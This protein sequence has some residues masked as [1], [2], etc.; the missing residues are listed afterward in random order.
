MK[1]ASKAILGALIGVLGLCSTWNIRAEDVAYQPIGPFGTLNN[2]D[3]SLIIPNNKA[4]DL[5]NVDI[6]PEGASVKKRK[7]YAISQ[8]LAVTTS[9]VHGVHYFYDSNGNDVAIF[10]N[11]NRISASIGG[12]AASVI[13][14]SAPNGATNQCVDSQGFAYCANTSRTSIIKTNGQTV[15]SL[16]GFTSTGTMVAVTPERLVQAGLS[17]APNDIV[18]SKANDFTTWTVGTQATDPISFTVTAPGPKITHI[19]YAFDRIIWFKSTSFGYILIGNAPAFEDWQVVTFDPNIGTLDNTSVYRDGVL[20]FRGQDGHIYGFD[21][22]GLKKLTRDIQETID[23]SQTRISNSWTQTTSG[24]FAAGNFSPAVYADTITVSAQLQLTFP[25]TF[26]TLRT[27]DTV[28]AKPVWDKFFSGSGTG[29]ATVSGGSLLL[30][31]DGNALGRSNLGTVEKLTD[32]RQGTTYYITV[33]SF[34]ADSGHLSDLYWTFRSTATASSNPDAAGTVIDFES[35]TTA[36]ITVANFTLLGKSGASS[37]TG[38]Y[39]IPAQISFYLSTTTYQLTI[40]GSVALSGTHTAPNEANYTY[41]SYLKGSAGSATC[42]IDSFQVNPETMT[43]LSAVNNAPNLTSWDSFTATFFNGTVGSHNFFIRSS[44]NSFTV[45]SSTPS[46]TAVTSGNTPTVSTG[47][48]FQIRD[49]MVNTSTSSDMPILYEFT[50]SWFEGGAVDKS[51]AT[52]FKEAIWWSVTSGVGQT[53]N[54]KILYYDMINDGMTL[55]NLP[56]NGFYIRQESL[57][58]GSSSGGYIYK[59]GDVNNDAGAAINAYW[60]SK[61]FVMGSPY[62]DKEAVNISMAAKTVA[63]SSMT[64]TYTLDGSSSTAYAVSFNSSNGFIKSN[65][66]LPLG[67]I[68]QTFNIQFGN[69][70][71]DQFF[72]VYALQAGYR[73]KSW[74]PE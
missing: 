48:Y 36:R 69:N 17:S 34:P 18:F 64:V 19:T 49:D 56:S 67:K 13:M 9:A 52:Y 65:K 37:T 47:T 63:N 33:S 29:D 46:W 60:K 15:S 50:Q 31:H 10:F 12:A 7:G 27:T 62:Q 28:G 61:D 30:R 73:L 51:Y 44:T 70:V 72:E 57:Y 11:D 16:S 22:T 3:G 32:Y 26:D 53:T 14:S 68:G 4:Q 21:G 39:A 54:N 6:S 5:L 41:L 23:N 1:R 24:D 71:A 40:N 25:E 55:Y 45:T 35:T 43:Y 2:T 42:Y 8:T 66:N 59:F 58:F 74:K 20:Y 38:D